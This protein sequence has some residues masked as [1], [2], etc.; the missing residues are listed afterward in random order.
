MSDIY[1]RDLE[2]DLTYDSSTGGYVLTSSIVTEYTLTIIPTPSDATVTL[3]AE[4]YTQSGNSITV[5]EGL[6]VT[7]SVVRLGYV[8]KSDSVVVDSDITLNITLDSEEVDPIDESTTVKELEVNSTVYDIVGKGILDQNSKTTQTK[9]VG[10]KAEYDA[11]GV[12]ADYCTYIITDDSVD[13]NTDSI[14]T[15]AEEINTLKGYDYVVDWQVPTS[16]NDYTWYRKYKS[17][18]V[19]QGGQITTTTS[20][21]SASGNT[22]ITFPQEFANTGYY[23]NMAGMI[24]NSSETVRILQFGITS[25]TTTTI[26]GNAAY[27]SSGGESY[28]A[29]VAT[30]QAAGMAA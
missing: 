11:L 20:T 12:Y 19:E 26:N 15:I 24:S 2:N 28:R 27:I 29:N 5:P 17:G 3:T 23:F 4:G 14:G 13:S 10:T 16:A 22:T 21:A 25:K 30:W 18:W 6:T 7:Y 1:I 9:W 8:Q